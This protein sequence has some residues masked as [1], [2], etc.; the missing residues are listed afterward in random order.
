MQRI[1]YQLMSSYDTRNRKH[2]SSSHTY[3]GKNNT[4][5]LIGHLLTKTLVEGIEFIFY[6]IYRITDMMYCRFKYD[7]AVV[8]IIHLITNQKANLRVLGPLLLAGLLSSVLLLKALLPLAL[9]VLAVLAV[10]LAS[11][12]TD[13][14][15]LPSALS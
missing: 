9:V 15:W 7:Y 1:S 10:V 3:N 6:S 5:Y 8:V 2:S 11:S 12:L 14:S 13:W 4:E